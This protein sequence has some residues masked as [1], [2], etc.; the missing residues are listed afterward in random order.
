MIEAEEL[1]IK[2]SETLIERGKQYGDAHDLYRGTAQLWS[3]Y[4]GQTVT[5]SDICMM[6]A[7]MKIG[8]LSQGVDDKEAHFDTYIDAVNYIALAQGLE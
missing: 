3:A 5:P 2:C 4:T 7:L 6:M 8:R 1:L